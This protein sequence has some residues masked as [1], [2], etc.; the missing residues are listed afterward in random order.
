MSLTK[1]QH[2]NLFIK[3]LKGKTIKS[4]RS[5]TNDECKDLGWYST[6]LVIEFTDGTCIFPQSDDE[7]NNG[8]AM[9]YYDYKS[10]EEKIIYT[11]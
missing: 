4:C 2:E 10:G 7:G 5:L 11:I 9:C 1:Q 8:G 3:L 6:P